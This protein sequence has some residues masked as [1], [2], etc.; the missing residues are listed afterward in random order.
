MIQVY[1]F[2]CQQTVSAISGFFAIMTVHPLVQAKAQAEIAQ[3]IGTERLP[4]YG[5]R[6]SLPYIEAVYKEVMRW[7]PIVPIGIPHRYDAKA[8]DE[9]QGV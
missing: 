8:D 3:V 6:D 9:F 2:I 1:D 5:D 4:T 7:N